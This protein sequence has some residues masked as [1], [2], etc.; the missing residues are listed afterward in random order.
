[1]DPLDS[2]EGTLVEM[3]N[4]EFL[5]H[6]ALQAYLGQEGSSASQDFQGTRAS[7]VL[8]ASL[9]LQESMEQEDLKLPESKGYL[10]FKDS[11]DHLETRDCQVPLGHQD[12]Q[13]DVGHLALKVPEEALPRVTVPTRDHLEIRDRQ[14]SMVQEENRGTVVCQGHLAPW[15]HQAL[16]DTK[17]SQVVMDKMARKDQWD[18][19]DHRGHRELWGPLERRVYLAILAFEGPLAL[20]G[21]L[22]HLQIWNPAPES[23]DFLEYQAQEDRKEPQGALEQGAPL[24][25]FVG[26]TA[27]TGR[28]SRSAAKCRVTRLSRWE[29]PAARPGGRGLRTSVPAGLQLP[30][31]T[32]VQGA[33]GSP[34]RTAGG[35]KTA[36]QGPPGLPDAQVTREKLAARERQREQL[37]RV[38]APREWGEEQQRQTRLHPA[39]WGSR[40]ERTLGD[41]ALNLCD[42]FHFS[43]YSSGPPGPLGD[44]GP[45]GLEPGHLSGF[46]LVLH[47]QTAT[48]PA[49][50][51]GMPR[52]WTGYSLLYLEGQEKAHNQDLGRRISSPSPR[53]A[54]NPLGEFYSLRSSSPI[55]P[56]L[57]EVFL[58][59]GE[60]LSYSVKLRIPGASKKLI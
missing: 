23:Q 35:E 47:S 53:L 24:D 13:A 8:Q 32:S 3:G 56:Y 31:A 5:D 28:A 29:R 40:L 1:M 57:R 18:S 55:S 14:A 34:A 33:K 51:E 46:L 26:L 49:C 10:V 44:P 25:Q 12:V 52:L 4:R 19:R 43:L 50:P 45:K 21:S 41:F 30:P 11:K 59:A 7:R 6:Q 38:Q 20:Q 36:R 54:R 15:A 37:P 17:A 60:V 27:L 39:F 2:T 48:E 42:R 58:Q 22:D 16:Q 9:V